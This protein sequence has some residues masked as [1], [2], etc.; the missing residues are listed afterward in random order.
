MNN[1]KPFSVGF[2]FEN[3]RL[4]QT[5]LTNAI[6]ERDAAINELD[7]ITNSRIWR[8]TALYRNLRKR[9]KNL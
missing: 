8:F 4:I 2:D 3:Q 1:E 5:I 7:K 6:N 9:Q